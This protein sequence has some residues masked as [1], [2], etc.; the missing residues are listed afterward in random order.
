MV[1]V[2]IKVTKGKTQ[3]KKKFDLY[4]LML[5]ALFFIVPISI[6][7]QS[8]TLSGKVRLSNGKPIAYAVVSLD[9]NNLY[10]ET[11]D[12]GEFEFKNLAFGSYNLEIK[13]VELTDFKSKI[14]FSEAKKKHDFTVHRS[15]AYDLDEMF[16]SVKTDK[17]EL[18]TKGFAMNVIEM[19]DAS[20]MSLQTN[21]LLDRTAGV[22]IRQDGGLGSNIQYNI[23][24]LSGRSVKIFIDG[25]PIDNFGSSFSL[26]SIPPALIERIEVYKGVVPIYLSQD[27]LGGAI[28]VVLKQKMNNT[29]NMSASYGSFN[30]NQYS[31][32]GSYRNE[33]TGFAVRASGFY[34]YSDNDYRVYGDHI[35]YVDYNGN[36]SYPKN[37]AKRFHD[38]YKSIGTKVETGFTDVKWADKFLVGGIISSQ[39]KDVQHGSTMDKVYGDRFTKRKSYVATL[40]Y[41]K[42][43]L[44][45]KGLS[46]KVDASYSNLIRQVVD[47]VGNMYDWS[48]KPI[49]DEKGNPIKYTSGAEV[50]SQKTLEKN[51]DKS[52][53]IRTNI[54][55]E[56]IENH[57]LN[58]N[59][60]YNGFKRGISDVLQVEAINNL[61]NTRDLTK[62]ILAFSYE[63]SLL[64]KKLRTSVFYKVYNQ[65]ATSNEPYK[66]TNIPLEGDLY[67]IN[68]ITEKVS[69][70]GYGV[71]LSYK[72][73]DYLYALGS[74]ERAIRLPAESEL[75]GSNADNL[76]PSFKLDPEVSTN[77]NIGINVGP[78][79]YRDHTVS[80]NAT[81]F[82][83]NVKGM[84]RESIDSRGIY[85]Q[86]ENLDDVLSRGFDMELNYSFRQSLFLNLSVSKFDVLFNR[87]YDKNGNEYL[88]YKTQIRNE[89]SFKLNANLSYRFRN[90]FDKGDMFSINYNIYYVKKFLRNWS[91]IG[92]ANLDEIPSQYPNDFGAVYQFS[93]RK[94]SISL[95]AKNIFNQRIYDNFGLQKPGRA[96]YGKV[97]YSIF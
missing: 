74:I 70:N 37:G 42:K 65:K 82:N 69:Y 27:A 44:L 17:R 87:Q 22:K 52:W 29:L 90:L 81:Y 6:I 84:I 60:F 93:N 43:D 35:R 9:N 96:F 4:K 7:A 77:Y 58:V 51:D 5:S 83:R 21:E 64:D 45:I 41:E 15:K 78:F 23:N 36:I 91:N 75:F 18:E 71:S 49:M 86:Y 32:N 2:D 26:S 28:N 92:G 24:G 97:T 8:G 1:F 38:T 76:L 63:S 88:Y 39:E 12:H 66:D 19:K 11:N 89:P 53:L 62:E 14:N 31:V 33:K 10:T 57:R 20:L 48:G 34:N 56:F 80:L 67:K 59:Y 95:D 47:T 16:I 54:A 61:T 68:K 13:S 79:N 94:I 55:Y 30:T 50:A 40:A 72:V 85:T 73:L 46:V 3:Y 25:I